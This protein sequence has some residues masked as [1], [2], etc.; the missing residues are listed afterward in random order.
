MH[1]KKKFLKN[2]NKKKIM[3]KSFFFGSKKR[4]MYSCNKI[5]KSNFFYKSLN[6]SRFVFFL[7]LK[8]IFKSFIK[9]GCAYRSYKFLSKFSL[10]VKLELKLS[11]FNFMRIIYAK[12]LPVLTFKNK[13]MGKTKYKLPYKNIG[14][15]K[16]TRIAARWAVVSVKEN[17]KFKFIEKLSDEMLSTFRNSGEMLNKKRS[18]YVDFFKNRN[19][20]RFLRYLKK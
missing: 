13:H 11:F 2:K 8:I 15:L 20:I 16:Q 4:F 5:N 17:K 3:S 19:N 10:K 14:L 12:T 9:S 7:F 18:Y 1:K 6:D